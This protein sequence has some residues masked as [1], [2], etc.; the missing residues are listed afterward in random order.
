ML[1]NKVYCDL[2]S[3]EKG[4]Y[5]NRY[6]D[7]DIISDSAAVKRINDTFITL[8]RR[9]SSKNSKYFIDP[10]SGFKIYWTSGGS[11]NSIWG[12]IWNNSKII[13]FGRN[14]YNNHEKAEMTIIPVDI[15][16]G[17]PNKFL[18]YDLV[19]R[20]DTV[21]INMLNG[22]TLT[23]VYSDTTLMDL[24]E[25]LNKTRGYNLPIGNTDPPIYTAEKVD[26]G[27]SNIETIIFRL[28]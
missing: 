7:I 13:S 21:T 10:H 19:N 8:F 15:I 14:I 5:K 11:G 20:W 3:T 18:V 23:D 17:N 4:F 6:K 1:Y 16:V 27:A 25:K 24:I 2:N 28:P 9:I 22:T 12:M 26:L